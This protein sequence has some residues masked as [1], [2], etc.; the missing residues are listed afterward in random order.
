MSI[1]T[2]TQL[3]D[4]L[5]AQE[6]RYTHSHEDDISFIPLENASIVHMDE[7]QLIFGIH[8]K[9][10]TIKVKAMSKEDMKGW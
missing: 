10:K 7:G 5:Q 4:L 8:E 6:E 2:V 3:P 1:Q 9:F